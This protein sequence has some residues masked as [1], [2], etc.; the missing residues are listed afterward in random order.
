MSDSE[1]V[2]QYELLRPTIAV[3]FEDASGT[4]R[5]L[6]Y[7]V[8]NQTA[9]WRVNTLLSKEPSTIAW[10]K[11]LRPG[12]VL[13]DVGAN[14]GMYTIFAAA[15]A[16]AKVYAF[17]PESQNFSILVKN[18][19][20]NQVQ[21]RVVPFCAAL[22]DQ[23]GIGL[24]H[25]SKFGWDGGES[26]HSFGAEVGFDLK[27]RSSPFAQGC[28]SYSI[29]QAVRDGVMP[30]PEYI[31]IDVDGFEHKVIQGAT[32]TLRDPRL[33]SL[34][35]EVNPALEE[36][37][38][39]VADLQRLGF[40]FDPIQVEQATRPEGGFAGC[41]EYVFDRAPLQDIRVQQ[42]FAE[43]RLPSPD[44]GDAALILDHVLQRIESTEVASEPFPHVVIDNVFPDSY[45][46][47][48]LALFPG[49]D[50]MMPLG[51]TGR[52][53]QGAF[54]QRLTTLFNDEQFAR[55][56]PPRLA[57]WSE[58]ASWLY[59]ERFIR[60]VV[61][62][63]LPWCA[64]RLA[65]LHD[66]NGGV[67][68]RSDALL[69]SDR[70]RYAI[71]PHTDAPHRLVSFLFY[72]PEDDRYRSLGTSFYRHEDPGFVCPGGPHYEFD[73]FSRT[74][75]VEFLPNRLLMFVRTGRS[76]HGVEEIREPGVDRRLLINN[77]RIL[78][79]G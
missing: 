78:G 66:L 53:S 35:I 20:T 34:S 48:M 51:E 6:R 49:P 21:D 32:E 3:K 33:R 19:M 25:L 73:R 31:K 37:R 64:N 60:A 22:S 26:C 8:P 68:L 15:L 43:T 17:E 67:D 41:A 9:L 27:P 75:M 7:F 59:S 71:G 1:I 38:A 29:D 65:V 18:I 4:I 63:F 45:Y 58:F 50:Q 44:R 56:D 46:R 2:K 74:G 5:K 57:F 79:P 72:M 76:F 61:A 11:R 42:G 16:G 10:L 54:Q 40:H 12:S 23:V 77:L 55:L 62:R 13:L 70:T 36:H 39:M 69:V 30:V 24:L 47:R 52:V 14:V 28:L